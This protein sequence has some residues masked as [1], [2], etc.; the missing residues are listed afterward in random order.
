MGCSSRNNTWNESIWFNEECEMTAL[1]YE[2][3]KTAWDYYS[4]P[5]IGIDAFWLTKNM[6]FELVL[7]DLNNLKAT[8]LEHYCD[9]NNLMEIIDGNNLKLKKI[10]AL[11]TRKNNK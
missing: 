4:E 7:R 3:V 11:I 5:K 8:T 10:I 2:K 9:G 1:P 6:K